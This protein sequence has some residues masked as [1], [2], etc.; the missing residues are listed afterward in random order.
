MSRGTRGTHDQHCTTGTKSTGI[1]DVVEELKDVVEELP[2]EADDSVGTLEEDVWEG[3]DSRRQVFTDDSFVFIDSKDT[4][5]PVAIA[6]AS[7]LLIRPSSTVI[8]SSLHTASPVVVYPS[9][10]TTMKSGQ[11]IPHGVSM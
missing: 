10:S 6:A 3:P 4:T 11:L 1:K 7:P 9:M 8:G 2:T 5:S